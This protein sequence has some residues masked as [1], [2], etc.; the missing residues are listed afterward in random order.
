[1]ISEHS[2]TRQVLLGQIL[3]S[4][5]KLSMQDLQRTLIFIKSLDQSS[6]GVSGR[7]LVALKDLFPQEDMEDI[8]QAIQ[9]ARDEEMRLI[10]Q[11]QSDATA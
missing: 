9:Q 3:E 2:T 10:E 4:L 8:A 6:F 11:A 1:M 5:D 7:N